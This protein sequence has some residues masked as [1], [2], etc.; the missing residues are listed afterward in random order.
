MGNVKLQTGSPREAGELCNEQ[1]PDWGNAK[2]VKCKE[3]WEF[4]NLL[5]TVLT[6]SFQG[7][8][9]KSAW[10]KGVIFYEKLNQQWGLGHGVDTAVCTCSEEMLEGRKVLPFQF[11]VLCWTGW[12]PHWYLSWGTH[13]GVDYN[14]M[15]KTPR[16]LLGWWFLCALAVEELLLLRLWCL[17]QTLLCPAFSHGI[18]K[19]NLSYSI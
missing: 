6:G 14:P 19:K 3:S 12:E 15:D 8:G 11:S 17:S 1:L 13:F 16:F 5:Q 9:V 10:L 4:V 18:G 2:D 7:R